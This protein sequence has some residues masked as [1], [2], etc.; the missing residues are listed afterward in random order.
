MAEVG[1]HQCAQWPD[2]DSSK[3]LKMAT[4]INAVGEG[5]FHQLCA[6]CDKARATPGSHFVRIFSR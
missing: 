5:S 3:W 4:M 2:L 1:L 6:Q